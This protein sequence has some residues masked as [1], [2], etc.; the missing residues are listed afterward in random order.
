M[1]PH[2]LVSLTEDA[3]LH[4][5]WGASPPH[6]TAQS[7]RISPFEHVHHP[8]QPHVLVSLTEDATLHTCWGDSPPHS[9]AQNTL[10]SPL[11][12]VHHPMQPRVLVSL[13]EDARRRS[14]DV[15]YCVRVDRVIIDAVECDVRLIVRGGR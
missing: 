3:T 15:D 5:C 4:T 7:I 13:T 14:R 1:Q 11:E 8:M 2:V 9:T 12:H 6:S 10:I